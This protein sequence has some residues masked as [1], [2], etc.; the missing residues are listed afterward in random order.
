MS[1]EQIKISDR[2]KKVLE[3]LVEV[4]RRSSGDYPCTFFKY[5]AKNT[6][7]DEKQSRRTVRALARKGLA[8]YQRG[9][10]DEDGMVA[11]SGYSATDKGLSLIPD[12]DEEPYNDEDVGDKDRER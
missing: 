6:G 4:Y 7:L 8:E 10:F 9:L 11:G 2:E 5:I 12:P 3:Y 1:N